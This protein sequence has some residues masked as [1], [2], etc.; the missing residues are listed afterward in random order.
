MTH[1]ERK[2]TIGRSPTCDIVLADESVSRIHAELTF[3]EGGKLLLTDCRSTQGTDLMNHGGEARAIRQEL[4]SPLDTLR[5]GAVSMP[6]KELLQAIHLKYPPVLNSGSAHKSA[7]PVA[8]NPAE[9]QA[10]VRCECGA[11][12]VKNIRCEVCG[13]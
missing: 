13:T 11:V 12:K 2:Y 10:L 9:G 3:L 4:I 8:A 1:P 7:P 5:F 6:V